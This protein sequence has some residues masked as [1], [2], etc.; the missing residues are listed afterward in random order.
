MVA[1]ADSAH[2]TT[3]TRSKRY[4]FNLIL[5]KRYIWYMFK[6]QLLIVVLIFPYC[7]Y[8]LI[9][10]HTAFLLETKQTSYFE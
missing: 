4:A 2:T 10:S 3:D 5:G 9:P 8:L 1:N 7:I 6:L